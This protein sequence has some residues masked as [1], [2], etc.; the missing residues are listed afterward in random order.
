LKGEDMNIKRGL[1]RLWVVASV[2]WVV[3]LVTMVII[4]AID[5]DKYPSAKDYQIL[6]LL[7]VVPPAALLAIGNI[8]NFVLWIIKG[9]KD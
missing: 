2:I 3:F 1:F 9:F 5:V 6:A 8:G 7:S 4:H